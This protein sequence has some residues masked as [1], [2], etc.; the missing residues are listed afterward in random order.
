[1]VANHK[2]DLPAVYPIID[3]GSD[4]AEE[5]R[6]VVALAR[7][8]ATNLPRSGVVQLRAKPLG[9]AAFVAL[10]RT[11]ADI[12]A[13]CQA[14]LIINDRA[15]V[16]AASGAHGVHLG[17][18]DLPVADAR[19]LLGDRAIIG[20]STH[21]VDEVRRA[22]DTGAD[23][24]GFGPIFS[25][26][27]KPG[28]RQPRGIDLLRKACEVSPLPVVA[29]GGISLDVAAQLWAAGATSLAII[30]EL[31]ASSDPASLLRSYRGAASAQAKLL[32]PS[33]S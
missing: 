18:E 27:T 26:P 14:T 9:G 11:V 4:G 8:L 21:S 28:V 10:A 32:P 29:I 25:S 7:A 31:A 22:A 5:N 1:M 13:P 33:S 23:Y 3:V 6:R 2:L 30:S 24:L 20:Y 15:D 16:A 17:D 12:L 19:R